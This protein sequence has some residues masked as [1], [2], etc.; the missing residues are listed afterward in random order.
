[1]PVIARSTAM[2]CSAAPI[3]SLFLRNVD[4]AFDAQVSPMKYQ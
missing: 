3:D 4:P 2:V 1:L